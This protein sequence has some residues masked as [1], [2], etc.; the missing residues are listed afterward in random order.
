MATL[1]FLLVGSWC[2]MPSSQAVK[3]KDLCELHQVSL[4]QGTEQEELECMLQAREGETRIWIC[5]ALILFLRKAN[6][7]KTSN[8]MQH[9][10]MGLRLGEILYQ[11]S[12]S[13]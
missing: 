6:T 9:K 11:V 1:D 10:L 2:P 7:G 4:V 12:R 5:N 13:S 3:A 8:H